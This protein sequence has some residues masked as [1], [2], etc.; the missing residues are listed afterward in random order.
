MSTT[1]MSFDDSRARSEIGYTSR[2]A[3]DALERAA[4]WFAE[5]G[6]VRSERL[7]RFTWAA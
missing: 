5:N 2:P 6:S 3:L 7:A 1:Q 4:R